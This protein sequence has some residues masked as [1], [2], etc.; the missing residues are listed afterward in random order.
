[1]LSD[2]LGRQGLKQPILGRKTQ[3]K[4]R[5]VLPPESTIINPIDTLPS[6]TPEQLEKIYKILDEEEKDNLDV[7]FTIVGN[8]GLTD[9]WKL[10]QAIMNGMDTCSIPIIPILSS[11]YTC[12]DMIEKVRESGRIIFP[13]EVPVGKALGRLSRKPVL[14]EP[15]SFPDDFDK[16]KI[17]TMLS[18]QREQPDPE[19]VKTILAASGFKLPFQ[20]DVFEK[21]G[22]SSV[23]GKV[24]FPVVMKVIGPLHKSDAGGVKIGIESI[25]KAEEAWDELMKIKDAR[26]VLIQQQ[27]EG[28][29]VIL[30]AKKEDRFGHLIMFGLGGIYTEALKDV[31]FALAPLGEE[32][33]LGMIQ[34]IKTLPILK[35]IRGE[36]G[37]SLE[38]LAGYLARLGLLVH[39]FPQIEEID[40]NP[41]KGFEENLYV[42]DARIIQSRD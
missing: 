22:L 35:G 28:T 4:L 25:E 27:V 17:E 41:V 20:Q 7:I 19:A 36:K 39:H 13:D 31:S 2:E 29:E 14:S 32:E 5:E 11:A 6:R 24:S 30:G 38:V 12:R 9:N 40:L 26:G 34:K 16:D 3:E 42:V 37:V 8:S 18:K 21:A 15:V 23:C 1:M 10:Y 33:A